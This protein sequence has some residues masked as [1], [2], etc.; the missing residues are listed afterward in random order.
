[1]S[2][3]VKYWGVRGSIACPSAKYV[4][5]GGNTSCVE[6]ACGGHR[7]VLDCGTGLRNFGHWMMRKNIKNVDI[8]MSHT[9][10]DHINGFPFFSPAF[11][12]GY[13]FTIR[14]G[15]LLSNGMSIKEVMAG[16]MNQPTFPVPIEAMQSKLN[17]EDFSA[18]D[19]FE[20]GNGILVK[21]LPLNHPDNATGYRIE[22]KGKVFCYITDTEHTPDR[23]DENVLALIDGAD[24]VTYD[25]TYTDREFPGK[26]GWGHSTW[27]EGVRLC[28]RAGAKRLAI[29]HHDP[30]HEDPFMERLEAEARL[31][32]EGAMVARE[33]M[34]IVL[35]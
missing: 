24:L 29:F 9:H 8:L 15:H 3:K 16:Q 6:V 4:M 20:L 25:C 7:I 10:W 21:T 27:Q 13:E 17:F 30:D 34:R 18:G 5:Y 12:D 19:N 22:Y 32:W 33:N 28:L 26:V 35:P 1:M 31:A 14:A 2:F 11:R 23:P